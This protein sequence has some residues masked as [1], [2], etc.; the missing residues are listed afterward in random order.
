[1]SKR[2]RGARTSK[3][4]SSNEINLVSARSRSN[5]EVK[6]YSRSISSDGYT[7]Q[8]R[9]RSNRKKVLIGVAV[10]VSALLLAAL[11][12]FFGFYVFIN[13]SLTIRSRI[14]ILTRLTDKRS[15]RPFYLLSL[16][17]MSR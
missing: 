8:R 3:R 15:R 11:Q 17:L 7:K 5:S 14:G 13:N 6:K 1:M 4:V 12:V 10:A 9:S 2:S 16:V